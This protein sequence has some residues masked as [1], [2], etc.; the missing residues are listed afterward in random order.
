MGTL[1]FAAGLLGLLAGM[2]ALFPVMLLD[3]MPLGTMRPARVQWLRD[4]VSWHSTLPEILTAWAVHA[5]S[6]WDHSC[7][8]WLAMALLG[9]CGL[10]C[11]IMIGPIVL[12]AIPPSK[13]EKR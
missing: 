8:A 9:T 1:G 5:P 13:D 2:L 4:V 10:G 12:M 6:L 7:F 11:A 3:M